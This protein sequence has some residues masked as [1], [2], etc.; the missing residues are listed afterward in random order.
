MCI[1]MQVVYGTSPEIKPTSR[2]T[3]TSTL[4]STMASL[5]WL[6][7]YI[8]QL[9][10]SDKT[11]KT[12]KTWTRW[13]NWMFFSASSDC[14][15]EDSA[16]PVRTR[17]WVVPTLHLRKL[18]SERSLKVR[19]SLCDVLVLV[20]TV[21]ADKTKNDWANKCVVAARCVCHSLLP[22]ETTLWRSRES[23]TWSPSTME[24]M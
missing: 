12:Y 9:L 23:T 8:I 4:P 14:H 1:L 24:L 5:T 18:P 7:F 6:R 3:I 17:C 13:V 21:L 16:P 2:A 15:R 19:P 10:E 22:S 11:P 20:L